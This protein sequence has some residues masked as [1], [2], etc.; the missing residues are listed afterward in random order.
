MKPNKMNRH[1]GDTKSMIQDNQNI[2]YLLTSTTKY[3]IWQLK[4]ELLGKKG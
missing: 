4:Q 1:I 2:E 3:R